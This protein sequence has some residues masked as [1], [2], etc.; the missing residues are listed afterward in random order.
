MRIAEQKRTTKETDIELK[1][2]LDG[3]GEY[4]INTPNTFFNHMMEAFCCHSGID[5]ELN[6]KSL[7]NNMHH[8]VEDCAIVTGLAVKV[9]LQDK[10]GIKRYS[11]IILPMDDA[12]ILCA[13][14]ISNRPYFKLDMTIEQEK[15]QDFETVLFYHFMYSFSMNLGLCLHIKK[16][17]GFDPH[18]IIEAGFKALAKALREAITIVDT[19]ILSSKGSL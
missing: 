9:A 16:L 11:H 19:K 6:A 15:T 2:N 18:H 17:D 7:D 10:I 14:D 8:L 13:L 12:L 4:K 1:I 5:M 3:K